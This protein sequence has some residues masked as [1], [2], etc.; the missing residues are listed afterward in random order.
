[1]RRM[2]ENKKLQQKRRAKK[3]RRKL[4]EG[5]LIV[6]DKLDMEY[7]IM[8]L[9]V[10]IILFPLSKSLSSKILF[11]QPKPLTIVSVVHTQNLSHNYSLITTSNKNN[12]P[13][14]ILDLRNLS[15]LKETIKSKRQTN[16]R[17]SSFSHNQ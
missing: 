13:R 4:K 10:T 2:K 1:M 3:K 11:S 9:I 5:L 7:E 16:I 15:V 6:M 17:L 8:I 14:S 12:S